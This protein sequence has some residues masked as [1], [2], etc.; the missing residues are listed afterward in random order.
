MWGSF[1]DQVGAGAGGTK[2]F[3]SIKVFTNGE[4]AKVLY[5]I[6]KNNEEIV[7][8]IKY[9]QLIVM[10]ANLTKIKSK[11]INEHRKLIKPDDFVPPDNL[12][13]INGVKDG[14]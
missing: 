6:C 7:E 1:T 4:E 12:I 14:Y 5:P 13:E 9:I 3:R 2:T 8:T 11:K 10:N